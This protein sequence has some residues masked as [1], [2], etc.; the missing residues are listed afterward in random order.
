MPV[1]PIKQIKLMKKE[2]RNG[3]NHLLYNLHL[4]SSVSAVRKN[5]GKKRTAPTASGWHKKLTAHLI[6]IKETSHK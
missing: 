4:S 3:E 6:C 5:A 1:P 2:K